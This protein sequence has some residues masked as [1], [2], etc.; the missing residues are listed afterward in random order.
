MD[1]W[2][3]K[4]P[5]PNANGVQYLREQLENNEGREVPLVEMFDVICSGTW[6]HV[7]G[8]RRRFGIY[9]GG[10][11]APGRLGDY[12]QP[13]TAYFRRSTLQIARV[14]PV[15]TEYTLAKG[16]AIPLT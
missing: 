9:L 6:R 1:E 15:L 10:D 5:L 3:L 11:Q 16:R 12:Q 7:V 8:A 4:R 13:R 14:P 2:D